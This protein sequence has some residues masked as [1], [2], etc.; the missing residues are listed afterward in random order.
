MTAK[1]TKKTDNKKDP[2]LTKP[3]FGSKF[4]QFEKLYVI[5]GY[6]LYEIADD[7]DLNYGSLRVYSSRHN[8]GQKRKKHMETVNL[9]VTQKIR[10]R[11]E[12]R[13]HELIQKNNRRAKHF[14]LI[15]KVCLG[16]MNQGMFR[17]KENPEIYKVALSAKEL[18]AITAAYLEAVK[19]EMLQDGQAVEIKTITKEDAR[20]PVFEAILKQEDLLVEAEDQAEASNKEAEKL[21]KQIKILKSR[22]NGNT[23]ANAQEKKPKKSNPKGDD[24][25]IQ[26]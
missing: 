18:R 22:Q 14:R 17:D 5:D 10:E 4:N 21:R 16:L 9:T 11:V 8:W 23:Q 25:N 12:Q 7:Y 6:T 15:Q 2:E 26:A 1:K 13:S 20:N 19:G 24:R 3:K